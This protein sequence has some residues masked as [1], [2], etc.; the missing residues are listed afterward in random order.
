MLL[1]ACN[2]SGTVKEKTK[3][4]A[5]QSRN[6]IRAVSEGPVFSGD[7]IAPE[8]IPRKNKKRRDSVTKSTK[9]KLGS[10]DHDGLERRMGVVGCQGARQDLV[11][12]RVLRVL[13]AFF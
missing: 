12:L 2:V 5:R 4:T 13:R 1:D 11:L 7:T 10:V 6:Q 9:K 3:D 8:V